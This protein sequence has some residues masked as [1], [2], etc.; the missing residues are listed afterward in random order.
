MKRIAWVVLALSGSTAFAYEIKVF[1]RI[2]VCTGTPVAEIVVLSDAS[3]NPVCRRMDAPGSIASPFMGAV[4]VNGQ[5]ASINTSDAQDIC[6]LIF[7]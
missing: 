1:N 6:R 7:R 4:S 2:G 3:G 5:C